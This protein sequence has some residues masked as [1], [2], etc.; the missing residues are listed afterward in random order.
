M[1]ENARLASGIGDPEVDVRGVSIPGEHH[2]QIQ[3]HGIKETLLDS[4]AFDVSLRLLGSAGDEIV[5]LMHSDDFDAGETSVPCLAHDFPEERGGA[6]VVRLL[7][8]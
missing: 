1:I 6:G 2:A 5:Q 7:H 8:P 4:T 3:R